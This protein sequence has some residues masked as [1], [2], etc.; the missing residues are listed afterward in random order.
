VGA[1]IGEMFHR[2]YR[3]E[4]ACKFQIHA[5]TGGAELNA[6]PREVVDHAMAQGPEIYSKG[7]QAAGGK[8]VWDAMVRKLDRVDPGYAV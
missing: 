4:R 5:M 2:M 7:G 3:L 8:L 1:T 6:L